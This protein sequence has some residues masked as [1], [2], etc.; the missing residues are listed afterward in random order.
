METKVEVL[1]KGP[2]LVHGTISITHKNGD[3]ETKKRT[4]AF[5]RCGASNTKPYCDG[6]HNTSGFND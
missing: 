6:H 2:L 3:V 1:E 4:T 5:C